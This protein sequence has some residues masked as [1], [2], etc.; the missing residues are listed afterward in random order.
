MFLSFLGEVSDKRSQNQVYCN[1]A[2]AYSQTENYSDA[3]E[4][5]EKAIQCCR[6][7][8]DHIEECL[9]T[10]GLAAIYFRQNDYDNAIK[11]YKTALGIL[12]KTEQSH[13]EHGERI[14]NKLAEAVEYQLRANKL[15]DGEE[16][17]GNPK[18][19]RRKHY[20]RRRGKPR[21]G[22]YNSLVAKGLEE[23]NDEI[24]GSSSS[25][26]DSEDGDSELS[27]SEASAPR[28]QQR[29]SSMRER[30]APEEHIQSYPEDNKDSIR[31]SKRGQYQRVRELSERNGNV[32]MVGASERDERSRID[33][34][35]ESKKDS[36]TC[37]IQ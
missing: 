34:A 30:K 17:E 15:Q 14:V 27:S 9:A 8:E 12:T 2:F 21:Y 1:L 10:E 5:F 16:V 31:D 6:E 37:C 11:N 28:E 3:K 4:A 19:R 22:K 35:D 24:E 33:S 29:S 25:F 23:T 13:S 18:S 20:G 26:S 36:R 7:S 32:H